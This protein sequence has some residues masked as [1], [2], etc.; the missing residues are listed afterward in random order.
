MVPSSDG[1]ATASGGAPRPSSGKRGKPAR[2]QT[3]RPSSSSAGGDNS[4]GPK[5]RGTKDTD[6]KGSK[7]TKSQK[8][9]ADPPAA[10]AAAAANKPA[11][12]PKQAA[13]QAQPS[14][15]PPKDPVISPCSGEDLFQYANEVDSSWQHPAKEFMPPSFSGVSTIF[16][17]PMGLVTAYHSD[18]G[19]TKTQAFVFRSLLRNCAEYR[20]APQSAEDSSNTQKYVHSSQ[21]AANVNR[22]RLGS[23]AAFKSLASNPLM[24]FCNWMGTLKDR[25]STYL[26]DHGAKLTEATGDLVIRI[27]TGRGLKARFGQAEKKK[28]VFAVSTNPR[29]LK[30]DSWF[31][32]ETRQAMIK[33]QA[34]M[35]NGDTS[36]CFYQ[37]MTQRPAGADE[38]NLDNESAACFDATVPA[39]RQ[40]VRKSM[41]DVLDRDKNRIPFPSSGCFKHLGMDGIK[42][43]GSIKADLG[44]EPDF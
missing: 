23:H 12:A 4:S 28:F 39:I 40:M 15:L 31:R 19:L 26:R 14:A 21:K 2:K 3:S 16:Q 6:K 43:K 35:G 20:G 44:K 17:D 22:G 27:D 24:T 38:T 37:L 25:R 36:A 34:Y 18:S 5:K 9:A 13:T 1:D 30:T 32:D 11:A 41:R 8:A 33:E 29:I 7:R 42:L 10:S